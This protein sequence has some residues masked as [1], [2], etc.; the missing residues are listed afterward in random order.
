MKVIGLGDTHGRVRWKII[1]S[2]NEDADKLVF[3]GDYFDTHGNVTPEQQ[4]NNF[5]DIIAFKRDNMNK[6]ILLIGNHDY[7][8]M[9]GVDE[10]Y[11]GYNE[12]YAKDINIILEEALSENLL[13]MCFVS[14][15]Y[16]FTHAGITNTWAN[17]N[18]IDVNVNGLENSINNLFKTNRGAFKFTPNRLGFG[19]NSGNDITQTPIWVRLPSLDMDIIPNVVCVVGH[20]PQKAID[21]RHNIIAIDTLGISDEYLIIEN[22]IPKVGN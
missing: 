19:S 9:T 3:I 10:T 21:V 2:N 1:V 8:Y 22:S 18:N 7:H 15:N 17:A 4:I 13:Q 20:T 12:E 14:D 11:S 6:V 16:V 5:K